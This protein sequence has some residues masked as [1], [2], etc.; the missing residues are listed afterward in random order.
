MK[1]FQDCLASV[2]SKANKCPHLQAWQVDCLQEL[3]TLQYDMIEEHHTTEDNILAPHITSLGFFH[4]SLSVVCKK[5]LLS[6]WLVQGCTTLLSSSNVRVGDQL[7][8]IRHFLWRMWREV[9]DNS[10]VRLRH[11]GEWRIPSWRRTQ[12]TDKWRAKGRPL[13]C[14]LRCYYCHPT[15]YCTNWW[16]L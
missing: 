7:A 14:L 3:F 10:S 15:A 9:T 12:M 1:Q 13:S 5:I 16:R 8:I 11:D 4:E 6:W 2:R